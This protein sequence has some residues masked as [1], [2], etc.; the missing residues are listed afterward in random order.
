M[1]TS[2]D[3]SKSDLAVSLEALY[4]DS[5]SRQNSVI[6]EPTSPH[7]QGTL[8]PL[9]LNLTSNLTFSHYHQAD[10]S[11]QTTII[12]PLGHCNSFLTSF[13]VSI[14]ASCALKSN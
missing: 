12:F 9:P 13:P 4:I 6:L 8:S 10:N 3:L 11:E 14:L 5:N 1:R 2:S 7:T